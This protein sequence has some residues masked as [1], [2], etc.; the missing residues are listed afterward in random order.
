MHFCVDELRLL[1]ALVP[2][3]A[4]AWNWMGKYVGVFMSY[5]TRPPLMGLPPPPE[6]PQC[7]K[8]G[9]KKP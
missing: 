8:D 7:C 6:P 2:V 4:L 1:L 9:H 5:V 3:V